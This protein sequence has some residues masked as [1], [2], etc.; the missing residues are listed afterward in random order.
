MIRKSLDK[1]LQDNM[2]DVL[3]ETSLLPNLM[4]A[5]ISTIGILIIHK[6][7]RRYNEIFQRHFALIVYHEDSV[8]LLENSLLNA[9]TA[10]YGAAYINLRPAMETAVKGVLLDSLI[11][12]EVRHRILEESKRL[13]SDISWLPKIVEHIEQRAPSSSA[14]ILSIIDSVDSENRRKL[15]FSTLINLLVSLDIFDNTIRGVLHDTYQ[16]LSAIVHRSVPSYTEA[17]MRKMW[18]PWEL[19][20]DSEQLGKFIKTFKNVVRVLSYGILK[21]LSMDLPEDFEPSD[22]VYKST[23][24]LFERLGFD[25]HIKVL[26]KALS[27]DRFPQL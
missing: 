24:E 19:V 13:Y 8:Y 14:E 22:E 5:Y 25:E 21:Y 10:H 17:G 2:I 26:N 15:N 6:N 4:R 7:K 3:K 23:Y 11:L 12:Q 18:I 27:K 9:L 20:P 16:F 1:A